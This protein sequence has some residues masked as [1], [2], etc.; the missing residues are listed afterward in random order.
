MLRL[1][2]VRL[3]NIVSLGFQSMNWDA[4]LN[5]TLLKFDSQAINHG[6]MK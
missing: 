3:D 5:H 1:P 2:L 6:F 4:A